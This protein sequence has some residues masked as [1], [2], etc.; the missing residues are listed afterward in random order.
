MIEQIIQAALIAV[1]SGLVS[2]TVTIAAIKVELR[3]LR[4][5]V[6]KHEARLTNLE[7]T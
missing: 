2:S 7:T 4:S 3:W 1:V 6:D 5:D